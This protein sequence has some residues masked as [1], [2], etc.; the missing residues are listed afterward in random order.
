MLELVEDSPAVTTDG[1]E[2]RW[3]VVRPVSGQTGILLARAD[4]EGQREVAGNQ[5]AGRVGWTT[6]MRSISG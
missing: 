3:V 5:F 2:K 6:L 1:R 4:S